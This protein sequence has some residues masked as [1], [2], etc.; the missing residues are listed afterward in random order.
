MRKGEELTE[1][2][3]FSQ[4]LPPTGTVPMAIPHFAVLYS[5]QCH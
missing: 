5:F 3:V 1:N 2:G 4:W